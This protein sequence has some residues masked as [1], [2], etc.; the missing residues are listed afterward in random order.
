MV[1]AM[2]TFM[3]VHFGTFSCLLF[4]QPQHGSYCHAARRLSSEEHQPLLYIC[5]QVA[6][7]EGCPPSA[8]QYAHVTLYPDQVALP[9][10]HLA[11]TLHRIEEIIPVHGNA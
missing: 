1:I 11:T 10:V 8:V 9:S 5:C 3:N 2:L 7:D 4:Q 6:T